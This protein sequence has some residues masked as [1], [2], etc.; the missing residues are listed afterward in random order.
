MRAWTVDADD[1]QIADDLDATL[2][3]RTPWIE[4]FL[5]EKRSDRFIV[6]ATKGFGK[7][8]LLKAKRIAYAEGTAVCI[9]ENGLLDKPIGDKVFNAAMVALYGEST[10]N[11]KRIWLIAIA[12]ATLKRL[13]MT[14]GLRVNP[15]LHALLANP[16]LTS[17]IDHFVNLLDFERGDL[18]K[19]ANET[20]NQLI[21]RLRTISTPVAIFIDSIDEYFNKHVTTREPTRASHAGE[22]SPN[23]WYFSQMGLVEVAYQLRR[24]SH[25]LKVFV[26]VR[27]EAFVKLEDT[28][29]MAQQYRGSTVDIV[30]S[31]ASL[32]EIF[33]NNIRRETPRNLVHPGRLKT[34]PIDAFLGTAAFTHDS[35]GETEDVFEYVCR[36]T[37]RRP[38]DFMTIGRKLSELGPEERRQESL[39]KQAIQQGATAI[40]HEYINEIQPYLGGID[41]YRLFP[42]LDRNVLQRDD[43]DRIFLEYADSTGTLD[44]PLHVFSALFRAGLLGV[45]DVDL[46]TGRTVQKFLLPGERAFEHG[47]GLPESSHYLVH[48]ILTSLVAEANPG[49]ARNLDRQ[50]EIGSGRAWVDAGADEPLCAVRADILHFSAF[51]RAGARETQV[52][53]ALHRAVERRR[54]QCVFVQE[55]GDAFL[56]LHRQPREAISVAKGIQVELFEATGEA[57]L[58]I[59]M[60]YGR[61]GLERNRSG[62]AVA[63]RRGFSVLR[64]VARIEPLVEPSQIWVTERFKDALEQAPSFYR[65]EL[66][67]PDV[68]P[69]VRSADGAFNV[70]KPGSTEE[71]ELVRLFRVVEPGR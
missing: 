55:D 62:E 12:A 13:D 23:V 60:D 11:W 70:R 28:T 65:V 56:L 35:S 17:V 43:C 49:Y 48:P 25:Q 15:Q 53:D 42:L 3:H 5:E 32:R 40:A 8:L 47:D 26:A 16:N 6:T 24:V 10:D 36:H 29:S 20:D 34:D 9:P 52:R 66:I 27:K 54:A 41:L 63:V 31:P 38:R 7:T 45:V 21:P 30:Y 18:F 64:N 2:L 67:G 57:E 1:I 46:A 33:L 68:R 59:A 51:I 69:E 22:L 19:S 39:A 4:S 50:N 44:E 58:R 61:V 37:L 14:D 71:D